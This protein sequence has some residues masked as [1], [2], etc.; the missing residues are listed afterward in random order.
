MAE[1]EATGAAF[2]VRRGGQPQEAADPAS[3]ARWQRLE[4]LLAGRARQPGQLIPL[5]Q[6]IQGLFG[7]LPRPA[8][9]RLAD[10][11]RLSLNRIYGVATFY[12]QFRLQPRG[13]HVVRVCVGTA[14][15]VR[16]SARIMQRVQEELGV[17]AGETTA[18][19]IFSLEPV[20][21][22]GCCGLAPVMMVD[23]TPYGKLTPERAQQVLRRYRRE[24]M[25]RQGRDPVAG[26]QA[27]DA[28]AAC[29][30]HFPA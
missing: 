8:L 26:A 23:E 2:P 16:G 12:A 20:A 6:E 1:G 5:L 17:G 18:D 21:C 19:G 7:Y 28:G 25:A 10:E 11:S 3:D 14:C 27:A 24:A 29:D 15:H 13:L 30:A 9:E 22:L 4:E